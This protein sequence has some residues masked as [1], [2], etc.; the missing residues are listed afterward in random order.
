VP[1]VNIPLYWVRPQ[2][3]LSGEAGAHRFLW[4]MHYQPLNEPPS[5]S[6]GAIYEDTPPAA[7][8]PW[9]MPGTYYARLKVHGKLYSQKFEVVMDPRVKT[10]RK[11][12]QLQHDLSYQCYKD[13]GNAEMLKETIEDSERRLEHMMTNSAKAEE[14]KKQIKAQFKWP[15]YYDRRD[16]AKLLVQRLQSI[17]HRLQASD[18]SLT[19]QDVASAKET[20]DAFVKLVG[21]AFWTQN[22]IDKIEGRRR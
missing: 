15:D 2:H 3:T 18:W 16:Y 22:E 17:F 4:D 7:T 13:L 19:Q 9:V 6:M 10:S 5:F 14:L 21:Q 1:E 8:S 20:H 11:D 12:L